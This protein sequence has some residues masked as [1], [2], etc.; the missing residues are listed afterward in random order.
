MSKAIQPLLFTISFLF[1]QFSPTVPSNVFRFSVGANYSES[2]WSLDEQ[3]FNLRGVRRH[4]FDFMIHSNSLRFSS[5]YDLYHNGSLLLDSTQT[6]EHWLTQFN[7]DYGFSIP[8]FGAQAIDTSK[9]V[10]L[11]GSFLES[12]T[13]NVSGKSIKI[14]YG[15]SNEVTLSIAIPLLD[16]YTINRSINKFNSSPLLNGDVL[17]AYH[18]NTQNEFIDFMDTDDFRNLDGGLKD[19]IQSIFN[20]FYTHSSE[21]SVLWATH[22]GNDPINN[23]LINSRFISSDIGSDTISLED[24]V[25]YYYPDKRESSGVDDVIVGATILLNGTPSWASTGNSKVLYAKIQLTI[26]YG[27]TLSSFKQSGSNQFK[28]IKIGSGVSRLGLGLYG[29]TGLKRGKNGMLFFQTFL[30]FSSSEILNTPIGLFSGGHTHPD[31]ILNQIGDTYKFNE[32]FWLRAKVGGDFKISPN[33]FR[34]R[35]ELEHTQKM[36][37]SFISNDLEWDKWMQSHRGYSSAFKRLDFSA[38]VWGLN[39][40]S[41]HKLGAISFDIYGGVKMSL[42]SENIYSGWT[43]YSGITTYYQGW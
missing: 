25:S 26:P 30:Q 29:A 1:G 31:S 36:E 43:V 18:I 41:S 38:E 34:L 21:Y 5:N 10:N 42:F 23:L 22:G 11:I 2:N 8:V 4:Y 3:E 33:R 9:S 40:N 14:D 28:E 7:S 6:I 19:T 37:D 17:L 16:S 24:L 15:I 20:T 35:F 39:S 13:K 12:R 32:G 27:S